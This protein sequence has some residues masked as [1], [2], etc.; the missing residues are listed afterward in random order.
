MCLKV[1][2]YLDLFTGMCICA[3]IS[4]QIFG[5]YTYFLQNYIYIE[6]YLH[7]HAH[8]VTHTHKLSEQLHLHLNL[9]PSIHAHLVPK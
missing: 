3:L 6:I 2:L 8:T 4:L 1:H 5:K 7:T 9:F